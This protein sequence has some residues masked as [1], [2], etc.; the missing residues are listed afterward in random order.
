MYRNNETISYD[1]GIAGINTDPGGMSLSGSS[2]DAFWD[3]HQHRSSIDDSS[4]G[5]ESS[6]PPIRSCHANLRPPVIDIDHEF[7]A[8]VGGVHAGNHRALSPTAPSG[9]YSSSF[10]TSPTSSHY[11]GM[12][13][14][15]NEMKM[16]SSHVSHRDMQHM[17]HMWQ[18]AHSSRGEQG[19]TPVVSSWSSLAGAV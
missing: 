2:P 6:V 5:S 16:P 4:E 19:V 15:T 13:A 10:Q 12:I 3:T 9:P 17:S 7:A 1:I 11:C 18:T 8:A 14:S